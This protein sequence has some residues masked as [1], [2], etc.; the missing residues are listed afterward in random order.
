VHGFT[1]V[2][3]DVQSY[4][5]INDSQAGLLQIS[6]IVSYMTLSPVFGY[7]GDRYNR[8][9]LMAIGI[10]IWS[11]FTLASSFVPSSVS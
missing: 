9:N 2:L 3:Q 11:F 6:F 4:Y 1:G 5:S 10:L 7:L 8:K